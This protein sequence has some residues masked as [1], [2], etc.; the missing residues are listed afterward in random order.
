M[1]L[2]N[3]IRTLSDLRPNT[4]SEMFGIEENIILFI[5]GMHAH[6]ERQVRVLITGPH[7]SGK[8]LLAAHLYKSLGCENPNGVDPCNVCGNCRDADWY[9]DMSDARCYDSRGAVHDK[10]DELASGTVLMPG[11][12]AFLFENI[13]ALSSSSLNIIASRFDRKFHRGHMIMTATETQELPQSLRNRFTPLPLRYNKESMR[14]LGNH[15]AQKLSIK[16]D[17]D[18]LERLIDRTLCLPG[19]LLEFFWQLG[20]ISTA[21]TLESFH[22]PVLKLISPVSE[23]TN[24]RELGGLREQRKSMLLEGR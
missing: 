11:N 3:D 5:E 7:D 18:A 8:S 15:I 1:N 2:P 6:P 23:A 9:I 4:I 16:V 21:L 24:K 19:K 17:A 12:R 14:A 13:D 20:F 10:L 22:H